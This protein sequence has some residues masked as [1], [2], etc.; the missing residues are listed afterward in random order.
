MST[1]NFDASLLTKLR[2]DGTA[3]AFFFRQQQ[4]QTSAQPGIGVK[5]TNPQTG[6]F[7]ASNLTAVREGNTPQ[8]AQY[9]PTKITVMPCS[10][11]LPPPTGAD[12]SGNALVFNSYPYN[13]A[14]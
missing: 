4:L 7:D 14:S 11:E 5:V 3:A 8:T 6:N 10:C 12:L 13:I 1:R 9:F 2:G